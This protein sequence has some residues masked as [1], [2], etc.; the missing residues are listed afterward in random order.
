MKQRKTGRPT[1]GNDGW[2]PPVHKLTPRSHSSISIFILSAELIINVFVEATAYLYLS[3][4]NCVWRL[5]EYSIPFNSLPCSR[6]L[7][8]GQAK[9]NFQTATTTP[10]K[11]K[12]K[13]LRCLSPFN[14]VLLMCRRRQ[15]AVSWL[16]AGSSLFSRNVITY[17]HW[18]TVRCMSTA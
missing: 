11:I 10:H 16:Y 6:Y 12:K 8:L 18:Q 4:S 17:L 3:W 14:L 15:T 1:H 5:E 13:T 2:R 7:E 9:W